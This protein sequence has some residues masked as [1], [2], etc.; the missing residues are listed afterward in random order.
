[1]PI[2]ILTCGILM[3]HEYFSNLEE[4]TSHLLCLGLVQFSSASAYYAQH[5]EE[6]GNVLAPCVNAGCTAWCMDVTYVHV[7]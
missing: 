4:L 3:S 5:T 7:G 6:R 2:P 1:M